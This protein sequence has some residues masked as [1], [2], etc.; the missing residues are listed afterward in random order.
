MITQE[1]T[2]NRTV[3]YTTV[4]IATLYD[5]LPDEVIWIEHQDVAYVEHTAI[6]TSSIYDLNYLRSQEDIPDTLY[7]IMNGI[8]NDVIY[9]RLP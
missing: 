7:E 8:S 1:I 9:I 6:P 3:N 2:L 4:S 5:L